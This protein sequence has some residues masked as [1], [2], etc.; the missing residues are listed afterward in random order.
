MR[1]R[2]AAY[3]CTYNVW[4]TRVQRTRNACGVNCEASLHILVVARARNATHTQQLCRS[5]NDDIMTVI[6]GVRDNNT[7]TNIPQQQPP[8]RDSVYKSLLFIDLYLKIFNICYAHFIQKNVLLEK[9]VDRSGNW[10]SLSLKLRN[11]LP[12]SL[13]SHSLKTQN[14]PLYHYSES[15][16]ASKPP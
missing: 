15:S 1:V 4:E 12:T 16:L 9:I 11:A 8:Q 3:T 6:S 2:C 14:F 7:I 5:F 13:P 10:T